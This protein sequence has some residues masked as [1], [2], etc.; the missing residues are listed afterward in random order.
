MANLVPNDVFNLSLGN[1]STPFKVSQVQPN[2]S[3]TAS[4]NADNVDAY[5]VRL[6]QNVKVDYD[7]T[8]KTLRLTGSG[9]YNLIPMEFS[10]EYTL[11]Q[12]ADLKSQLESAVGGNPNLT[13][14][15]QT[16]FG[17]TGSLLE[18]ANV[19]GSYSAAQGQY[20]WSGNIKIDFTPE[21][22]V[23]DDDITC[24]TSALAATPIIPI[25]S[26]CNRLHCR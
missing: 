12:G 2:G 14:G 17:D 7:A 24:L 25:K 6:Y 9:L 10:Q 11:G 16:L 3:F 23:H 1:T 21:D 4:L 19:T 13:L 5:G 18:D 26:F 20:D 15:V 22:K 8:K